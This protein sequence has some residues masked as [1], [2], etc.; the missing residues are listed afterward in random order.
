[1]APSVCVKLSRSEFLRAAVFYNAIDVEGSC[2]LHICKSD[3]TNK[4]EKPSKNG[5]IE[6]KITLNLSRSDFLRR[7]NKHSNSKQNTNLLKTQMKSNV[8]ASYNLRKKDVSQ[9]PTKSIKRLRPQ[10]VVRKRMTSAVKLI[11]APKN[12]LKEG[13]IV[14]AKMRTYSAWPAVIKSFKKTCVTVQFFGDG[15]TGNIPY[16]AIGLFE[17][18]HELI[19]LNLQKKIVGYAKSVGHA[20][21]ILKIPEEFSIFNQI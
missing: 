2:D 9:L 1:M 13:L 16:D 19:K 8:L 21:A 20:E 12:V 17:I 3:F 5:R 6:K 7:S 11:I 15:T 18:N 14:L 4:A 10:N